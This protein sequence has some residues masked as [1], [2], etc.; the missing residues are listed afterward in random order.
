[1]SCC[2]RSEAII[3]LELIKSNQDVSKA[4]DSL[5]PGLK[6]TTPEELKKGEIPHISHDAGYFIAPPE[7]R[8][9]PEFNRC[10]M[11]AFTPFKIK[12]LVIRN[13]YVMAPMGTVGL[14][15]NQGAYNNRG[16]DY[17]VARA[18]GGIGLVTTGIQ[19]VSLDIEPLFPGILPCPRQNPPR[20]INHAKEMVEKCHSYGA[21]VFAQLTAGWG[22]AAIPSTVLDKK[23]LVAPSKQDNRFDPKLECREL[24]LEEVEEYVKCFVESAVICMKC[25]YDGVEIHAVH[26]GYLL[27]Q[28]T[29]EYY[30]KR[31]DKYGGNLENR[32]RFPSEIVQGIK[33]ACGKNFPVSLRYSVKS[34]IKGERQGAI[35]GEQF[36]ELGRDWAEGLEV[37]LHL[38]KAGYDMFSVDAGSY[39]SWYWNHPPSY[40][41]TGMYLPF[42]NFLKV[43]GLKVP[44]TTAGRM[45]DPR[46]TEIA[47]ARGQT[48]FIAMGRPTLADAD[49]VNKI[50]RGEYDT[51][52]PCVSCHDG[53]LN[54]MANLG[55]M[56]CAL[57]PATGREAEYEYTRRLKKK[58]VCVIGGGPAGLEFAMTC[59]IRG[60]EVTLV[61]KKDHL[62]GNLFVAGQ[63]SFK[64]DDI[65]L[66]RFY[67]KQFELLGITILLNTD[68]LN[69]QHCYKNHV[70]ALCSGATPII[71]PIF[72][73]PGVLLSED[74]MLKKHKIEG[75]VVVLGGG[76]VGIETALFM[77]RDLQITDLTVIE[78][79]PKVLGGGATTPHMSYWMMIDLLKFY[80]V[81]IFEKHAVTGVEGN[82]VEVTP[83]EGDRTPVFFKGTIINAIGYRPAPLKLSIQPK[84]LY[85]IGDCGS[86]S[87]IMTAIWDAREVANH[88]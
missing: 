30:N 85:T 40:F 32:L 27:D 81:K 47:L 72:D 57:N 49:I 64:H 43:G 77:A 82:V 18:R 75:P 65:E 58:N 60:H 53:C 62:G 35:P 69:I 48:D 78:K 5:C 37:A 3:P 16:V 61:E 68:F 10:T 26:E 29:M 84:E 36:V 54:R 24:K 50:G 20:Y 25:G 51:V 6:V 38:E 17:Y 67:E 41:G 74:I 8:N 39:D 76:L 28:F 21:K 7:N 87:N 59:A 63:P 1:M 42:S 4:V 14:V 52:R 2:E 79:L 11:M 88:V 55:T 9:C 23:N 46:L 44:V 80:G 31:T 71:P 56:S 45:E 22:R 12:N 13:R 66:I 73:K 15:D 70:V 34:Y 33:A 83:E 86:V 19:L